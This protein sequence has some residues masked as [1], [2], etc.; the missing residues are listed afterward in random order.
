MKLKIL[1][2][3]ASLSFTNFLSAQWNSNPAVNTTVSTSIFDQQDIRMVSDN[4]KGAVVSWVDFRANGTFSDIY[5]QRID[6]NGYSMWTA[7]GVVVCN[8]AF[9]QDGAKITEAGSGEVIIC[10][11][12]KRNGNWDIYAQKLDANG[13][14]LWS[15]NGISVCTKALVQKDPHLSSD[16]SGGAIIVW[17]DS[18]AGS[19]DIYV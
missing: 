16:G 2:Y 10:W 12:D 4:E 14:T 6:S 15:A 11:R 18:V 8:N 1:L 17:E 7:D 5:A 13:N 19:Y 3:A 9:D